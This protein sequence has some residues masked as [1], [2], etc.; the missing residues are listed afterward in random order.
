MA[1]YW[2]GKSTCI[3]T[4]FMLCNEGL[5]ADVERIGQCIHR[6]DKVVSVGVQLHS[7]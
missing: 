1:T 7:L 6:F 3:S 5:P 4:C 2:W